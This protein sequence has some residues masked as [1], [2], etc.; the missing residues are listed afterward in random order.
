MFLFWYECR[1]WYSKLIFEKGKIEMKHTKNMHFVDTPEARELYL[2]AINSSVLY[3][4]ML[5]AIEKNLEKKMQKG[6]FDAEKA[7]DAFYYVSEEA[8]RKYLKD[9]G[10]KFT[11]T[12]KWS[13]AVMMRDLFVAEH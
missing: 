11:V 3:F 10:Y 5:Q 12:E 2:V 7:I 8:A 4:R 9:F 6:T 1:K 13:A